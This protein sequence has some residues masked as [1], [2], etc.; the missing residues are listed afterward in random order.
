MKKKFVKRIYVSDKIYRSLVIKHDKKLIL[1]EKIENYFNKL[2]IKC[3]NFL[4][5]NNEIKALIVSLHPK[6]IKQN[7]IN[8]LL[9]SKL[10]ILMSNLIG[11][12]LIQ[13]SEK[14]KYI[15]VYDRSRKLSMH[16]GARYH[17]TREGGS[18]HT[19]NVNITEHWDY[20]MFSCLSKAEVG[21]ETILV[22]SNEVYDLLNKNFKFAKKIL[23]QNFFWEK[24]GVDTSL[25]KAPIIKRINDFV[26]FRYLRPYLESAH[27]KAK[28]PL[29]KNQLYALDVLDAILESSA[30]QY[31]FNMEKGDILFNLDSEVLHG[32]TSF[33]DNL[34][35]LP[36]DKISNKNQHRL[37]RTMLR[38]WIKNHSL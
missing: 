35:S 6:H 14:E 31:R 22:N 33:S 19:D 21:G 17:Q 11:E 29:T 3:K 2:I 12:P 10:T 5:K 32:R 1:N 15:K 25:Y 30:L 34:N 28:K 7:K 8:P 20:L 23:S 37:K 18:I 13:N 26:K 4:D 36:L 9:I 27:L 24:R 38:I 16:K